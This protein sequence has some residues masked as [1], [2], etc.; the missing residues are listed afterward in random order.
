MA[1]SFSDRQLEIIDASAQ[2]LTHSGV[3][4]LTIKNLAK[5][6]NFSESAIYRHFNSK[7]EIVLAMLRFV[8]QNVDNG[9]I[10]KVKPEHSPVDKLKL[11]FR[12]QFAFFQQHSHLAVA[13]FSDGLLEE[14]K[15]I[16]E[17][18]FL[19]MASRKKLIAPIIIEG[20]QNGDFTKAIK[21]DELVH[22]IMGTVR[23]HMYKWRIDQFQQDVAKSGNKLLE[24]LI[25][26]IVI[27]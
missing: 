27:A 17:Q 12:N 1:T 2:L 11:L 15:A 26:L 6:M 9:Y 3:S 24:S 7:E 4:G 25:K 5:A 19:I 14:S 21:A 10:A 20:Q 22:I 16:N 13:L 8:L 23:L 18:I